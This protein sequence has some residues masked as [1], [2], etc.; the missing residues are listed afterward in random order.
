MGKVLW[1]R[2]RGSEGEGK[3]TYGGLF[4]WT[5]L[6]PTHFCGPDFRRV[7]CSHSHQFMA[8]SPKSPFFPFL[9]II[10]PLSFHALQ[11]AKRLRHVADKEGLQ[12]PDVSVEA[13]Q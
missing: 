11:M 9:S 8:F 6:L 13:K 5:S 10:Q 4:D 1:V 2:G 7:I 3:V 12:I